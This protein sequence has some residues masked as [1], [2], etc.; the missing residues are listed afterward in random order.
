MLETVAKADG[1]S[2]E[3][4]VQDSSRLAYNLRSA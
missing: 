2:D 3:V 4:L 1:R